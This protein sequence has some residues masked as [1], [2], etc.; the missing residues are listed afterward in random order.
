MEVRP[1]EILEA[2]PEIFILK[3]HKPQSK[4]SILD[5]KKKT[6]LNKRIFKS[7]KDITCISVIYKFL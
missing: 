1:L 7:C 5:F 3:N 4:I 2:D 6:N